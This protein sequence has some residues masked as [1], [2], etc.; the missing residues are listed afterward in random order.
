MRPS[1]LLAWLGPAL[2][3][4][5]AASWQLRLQEGGHAAVDMV[6]GAQA[7]NQ[8]GAPAAPRAVIVV[9]DAPQLLAALQ[10]PTWQGGP[11]SLF[12]P[13]PTHAE[14]DALLAAGVSGWWPDTLSASALN[15]ALALDRVRWQQGIDA[16]TQLDRAR[17]QLDERQ[18]VDR[19]KGVLMSARGI[20]EN[21]AFTLLRGAA[22]HANL[23]MGELSR[24]VTEAARWADA[25]NR[26]GQLRMLSQRLAKLAVQRWSALDARRARA[27]QDEALR[28][29]AD[30]LTHLRALPAPDTGSA[31]WAS[32]LATVQQASEDLSEALSGRLGADMLR[33]VDERADT[34]LAA[35]EQLIVA[36]E[37]ASGRRALHIINL[38]GRQRMRVQRVAKQALLAQSLGDAV[39][40]ASL[41]ALLDDFEAAL[42][43]LQAAPLSSN[44]IREVLHAAN[45]EWLHLL[46][47]LH[48]LNQEAGRLTLSQASDK[49]LSLFERLTA[50]YERSLQVIMA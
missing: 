23:R 31:P 22:M 14:A 46:R 42:R 25:M 8:V 48:Q 10:G 11:V 24:S 36:L 49:L 6:H 38:C 35:A 41:P 18:W 33:R 13:T 1:P 16:R 15:A 47:G 32:A 27:D 34:L 9:A 21:E 45:D 19:A 26:A 17:A 30:N 29:L 4:A 12:G 39:R 2:D 37:A 3:D 40:Q 44:D 28:R 5:Q 50:S 43:E 7:L 20:G